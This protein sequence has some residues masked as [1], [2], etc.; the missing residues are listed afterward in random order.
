[1]TNYIFHRLLLLIPVLVGVSFLVFLIA[2]ITPGDPARIMLGIHATPEAL[3]S[4][5]EALHLNDPFFTR[6]GR[7]LWNAL[8][9]DLGQSLRGQTPVLE[10]ILARLPSTLQLTVAALAFAIVSGVSIGLIAARNR[11]S[12]LD[13]SSMFVALVGLSIPPF[14]L[15]IILII[16]FGIKLKWVNVT[17]GTG[18]QDLILPAITLGLEPAAVFARLTRGS[19]LEVMKEDYV[20]TARSKGLKEPVIQFRHILRNALIPLVTYL[21]L[22]FADMLGGTVFIESVFARPGLGR[23]AINAISVR[24]FPQVQGVVLFVATFY[25]LLN[26]IVDLL[27]G[28]IDPRIRLA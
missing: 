28:L 12:L 20:R 21:G 4:L 11:G 10:E 17:G 8:H 19:V 7:F 18:L 15:A 24:D 16:I 26:L 23:F 14:W 22:L 9:G 27:Y 1:M 6:Y 3:A 2:E 5:R 13:G 25:V